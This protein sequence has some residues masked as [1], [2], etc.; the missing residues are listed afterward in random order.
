MLASEM[1]CVPGTSPEGGIGLRQ[2]KKKE[3]R[4]SLREGLPQPAITPAAGEA[5]GAISLVERNE[6]IPA[7]ETMY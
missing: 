7:A 4:D 1:K 3:E 6:N 2:V 5:A